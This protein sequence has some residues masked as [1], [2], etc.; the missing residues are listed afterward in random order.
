MSS[1][2]WGWFLAIIGT[3]AS[4][5]GVVFSWMAWVQ[6]AKAKEAAREAAEAARTRNLAHAFSSWV[7]LARDLLASVRNLDLDEASRVATELMSELSYHKGWRKG[8]G[9]QTT[10][11]DEVIRVLDFVSGYF[12]NEAIFIGSRHDLVRDCYTVLKRLREMA[13]IIDARLEGL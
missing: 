10:E 8:R 9:Q 6:A 11:I 5:A 13:G 12:E 1:T 7:A 2:A 3:L 4:V